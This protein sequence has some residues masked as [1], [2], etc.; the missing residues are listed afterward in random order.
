M[1]A[2]RSAGI[3]ARRQ[4]TRRCATCSFDDKVERR[5]KRRAK[6]A[7]VGGGDDDDACICTECKHCEVSGNGT[8]IAALASKVNEL[9]DMHLDEV[10]A[11][12]KPVFYAEAKDETSGGVEIRDDQ[13]RGKIDQKMRGQLR[14]LG[15]YVGMGAL[16]TKN[17]DMEAGRINGN[18]GV[19]ERIR[20][21]G[22]RRCKT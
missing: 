20:D 2:D 19:I 1:T 6:S 21:G 15:V 7:S 17:E 12:G 10:A 14:T 9:N 13:R 8:I 16:L 11:A 5:R 3:A 22:C 4:S 18:P